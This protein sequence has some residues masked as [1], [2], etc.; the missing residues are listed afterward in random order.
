[1][2]PIRDAST[3]SADLPAFARPPV[4]EVAASLQ[5]N[6]IEGLDAARL[7]L[8]WGRYRDRYPK[9]EIH[10]ALNA[11]VES[12]GPPTPH[13]VSFEFAAA[14]PP[15]RFWFLTERGTRL[16][17]V[18]HDRF[19][20]NWR[21]LETGEE[22]PHYPE[23]SGKLAEEFQEFET[24]LSEEGLAG[25][26]LNQVEL[27]YV[28]HLPAGSSK[29]RREPLQQM[30]RLWAGNPSG[31]TLPDPDELT[32]GAS[33]VM[34]GAEGPVGRLHIRLESR[35]R[36]ADNAPVYALHLVARGAPE[37]AG[38]AGALAAMDRGHR[39]IVQNFA[40]ITTPEMHRVWERTR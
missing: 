19:A 40:A 36:V 21:S 10:P 6:T 15:L 9:T 8:L 11:V 26:E 16:L 24:F 18:Q 37:G 22:Y 14:A 23:L 2:S 29:S 27:T 32:F 34:R 28:N 39:W 20:L 5:F 3:L 4:V 31:S 17:Q 35:Y 7:G 30:V 33:H 1:M 12:F 25:P 13:S 38:I